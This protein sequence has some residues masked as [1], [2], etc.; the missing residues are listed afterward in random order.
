MGKKAICIT[1]IFVFVSIFMAAAFN[2]TQGNAQTTAESQKV[3]IEIDKIG[4]DIGVAQEETVMPGG[5]KGMSQR[6]DKAEM[7]KAFAVLKRDYN[8]PD[9]TYFVTSSPHPAVTL[10]FI[11][12]LRPLDVNYLY[13]RP[14]GDEVDMCELQKV[15]G[16]P[17][18]DSNY[19]VRFEIIENGD[20]LFM[21]FNSDSPEATAQKAH[22]FEIPNIC[23]LTIPEIP[24]GKH[25]YL[26]ARGRYCVMVALAFNYINDCK[27]ISI[28]YHQ[29][30]YKCAAS[31]SD[32]IEI[33]EVTTRT[34]PND[35]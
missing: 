8:D 31:F 33:G 13:Q 9:A 17:E 22:S 23:K 12:A 21:N 2:A 34:L 16:I 25:L 27:S 7:E 32:E 26:H 6:W 4:R 19:G 20:K 11:N 1:T 35:L 30:D 14:G 29:N 15:K 10:A 18:A 3:I 24:T 5:N 28:A